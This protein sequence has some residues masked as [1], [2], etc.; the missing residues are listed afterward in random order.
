[1]FFRYLKGKELQF[2]G[3]LKQSCKM[4]SCGTGD[5]ET[6]KHG[7]HWELYWSNGLAGNWQ[8]AADSMKI[9]VDGSFWSPAVINY[10]YAIVLLK[11]DPEGNKKE[12]LDLLEGIE[13]ARK[14]IAGKSVPD[15]KFCARKAAQ[16]L[17]GKT[18][19]E[20]AFYEAAYIFNYLK[21]TNANAERAAVILDDVEKSLDNITTHD[22]PICK[23]LQA[24]F[25]GQ[26]GQIHEAIEI[27]EA[28]LD[29]MKENGNLWLYP[30]ANLEYGNMLR[31]E[32][33]KPEEIHAKFKI[34]KERT[35]HAFES[36][37]HYRVHGYSEL[38]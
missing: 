9:L 14:R 21:I 15:E 35:H 1:M 10:L 31:L 18:N 23:F 2:T 34:A 12:A 27:L 22:I 25:K 8:A 33:S 24:V 38:V 4:F 13:G 28:D 11:C 19:F 30:A 6:F 20:L 26:L 32:G 5:W 29:I 16:Y 37:L 7:C 36:R 3:E 17:E